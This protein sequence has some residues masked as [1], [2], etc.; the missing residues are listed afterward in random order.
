MPK[1]CKLRL[2]GFLRTLLSIFPRSIL[3]LLMY[4]VPRSFQ[5]LPD[6]FR[7]IYAKY[8][9][10]LRVAIDT[11]Y[12][13]ERDMLSG[14]FD[15][16]T[17]GIIDTI[18]RPGD[19]C[20]DIGANVGALSLAMAK[21][22][23][24]TGRVYAFEPG[25]LTYD[26]LMKNIELNPGFSDIITTYQMGL[27]DRVGELYWCEHESNR[28]DANLSDQPMPNSVLV[29]VGTVDLQFQNI[30]IEKLDFVKIDVESM[31]YEVI[32]GG[33]STWK[34]YRPVIY[35]ETLKEFEVYRK[36]PVFKYIED[37]LSGLGYAFYKIREDSSFVTTLYPD[38][39][40]NTL[41]LPEKVRKRLSI[42]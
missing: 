8:L 26:R 15:K 13:I 32:T 35:Y 6:G 39:S 17:I 18:V 21:K 5:I 30:P 29:P 10:D 1:S 16:T 3:T 14:V 9:G 28:G 31:E 24:A 12:P 41:A 37:L 25:K 2:V 38:L 34:K 19:C 20:L 42:E 22:T 4:R 33:M 11:R 40:T 23:T 7:L 27:S 36:K